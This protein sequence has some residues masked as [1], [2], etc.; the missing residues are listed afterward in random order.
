MDSSTM[1]TEINS[2]LPDSLSLTAAQEASLT[3]LLNAQTEQYGLAQALLIEKRSLLVKGNP[4]G[5]DKLDRNLLNIHQ[6]LI[7]LE[8]TRLALQAETGCTGGTLENLVQA[9][10]PA[11]AFHF[12][13]LR[14]GILS[15]LKDTQRLNRENQELLKLS[16]RWVRQTVKIIKGPES[17]E[18]TSYTANGAK[19]VGKDNA[20]VTMPSRSTINHSA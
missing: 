11:Q 2:T 18:T 7:D 8:R 19:P 6:K 14:N 16:L 13:N 4:E 9:L 5:L 1:Q 20:M 15:L 3:Q 12:G 10:P 17:L